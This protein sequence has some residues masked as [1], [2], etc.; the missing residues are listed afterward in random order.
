MEN[1]CAGSNL[2]RSQEGGSK[3]H[4]R[5]ARKLVIIHSEDLK[6]VGTLQ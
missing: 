1:M 4:M 2:L 6:V 5:I 3:F